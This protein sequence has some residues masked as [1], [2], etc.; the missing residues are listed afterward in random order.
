[1]SLFSRRTGGMGTLVAGVVLGYALSRLEEGTDSPA[2]ADHKEQIDPEI[3]GVRAELRKRTDEDL[4]EKPQ[5]EREQTTKQATEKKFHDLAEELKSVLQDKS[6][7][8]DLQKAHTEEGVS[9]TRLVYTNR[10]E[11]GGLRVSPAEGSAPYTVL[12]EYL[13]YS[14]KSNGLIP[15]GQTQLVTAYSID[16]LD[17]ALDALAAQS[18]PPTWEEG[19][20]DY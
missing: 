13:V 18:E 5:R 20:N 19:A 6:H 10:N 2:P 9:T 8:W 16:D 14:Q 7:R 4:D 15:N 1:M 3:E 12:V 11:L 17:V